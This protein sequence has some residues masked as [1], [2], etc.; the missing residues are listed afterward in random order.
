MY[1]NTLIFFSLLS[2][3][4]LLVCGRLITSNF[5]ELLSQARVVSF[6]TYIGV[7]LHLLYLFACIQKKILWEVPYFISIVLTRSKIVY[8]D[9]FYSGYLYF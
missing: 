4:S 7:L 1:P 9:S 5:Q 8:Q 2:L 6:L 3:L